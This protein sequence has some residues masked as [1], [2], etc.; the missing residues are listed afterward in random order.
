M[1]TSDVTSFPERF[2]RIDNL[3]RGDHHYLDADDVCL[4]LG[5]YTAR[6]GFAHS[7]TNNLI[8]NFKKPMDRE[9]R[10]EWHHKARNILIAA[11]ALYKAFGNADLRSYTFVPVPPSKDRTHPMYDDRMMVM[12]KKVS[13]LFHQNRGYRLDVRELIEQTQNTTAAHVT[14]ARPE[15]TEL[16]K[17]YEIQ[18]GMLANAKDR[19]VTCDD[20]LTSVCQKT[21]RQSPISR[22]F[23]IFN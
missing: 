20:V 2:T 22:R 19:I 14:N 4:F 17:L 9:G 3:T 10:P 16:V 7:A 1:M 13:D 15:P 5:E 6:K 18:K 21:P 11:E 8:I 12:L 23:I